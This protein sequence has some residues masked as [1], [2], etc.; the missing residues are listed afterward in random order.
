[1]RINPTNNQAFTSEDI[2]GAMEEV[3]NFETQL[4]IEVKK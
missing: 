4:L 1:M 3:E 2:A